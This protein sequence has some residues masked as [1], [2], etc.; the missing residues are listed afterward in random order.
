VAAM[1]GANA[2][3]SSSTTVR[4]FELGCASLAVVGLYAQLF[5]SIADLLKSDPPDGLFSWF[6]MSGCRGRAV[7]IFSSSCSGQ[8][9]TP[10][11]LIARHG[12]IPVSVQAMKRGAIEFLTKPFCDQDLL[13][14]IQLGLTRDGVRRENDKVLVALRERFGSLSHRKREVMINV[15]Q[16][17]LNK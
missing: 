16:V 17:G 3:A 10:N 9:V 13:D 4:P 14:A 12:D 8:H 15:A 2:T 5:A 7:L 11:Y 6:S 1:R